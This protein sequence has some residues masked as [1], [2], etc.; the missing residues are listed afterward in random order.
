MNA[1]HTPAATGA[2]VLL[3]QCLNAT[4]PKLLQ[5]L[6]GRQPGHAHALQQTAPAHAPILLH[7]LVKL[8]RAHP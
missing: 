6:Q 1:V 7:A 3:N 5:L 8:A 2:K 4:P